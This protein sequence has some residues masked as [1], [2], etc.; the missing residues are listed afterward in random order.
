MRTKLGDR[1]E[2]SFDVIFPFAFLEVQHPKAGEV[3]DVD[4]HRLLVI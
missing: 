3:Q 4:G 1:N 2:L